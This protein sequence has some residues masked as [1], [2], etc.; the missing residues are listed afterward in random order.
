VHEVASEWFDL[1][2]QSLLS[3]PG[4]VRELRRVV[5]SQAGKRFY[6]DYVARLA[7]RVPK[8]RKHLSHFE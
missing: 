5:L 4:C 6:R 7:R 8:Y 3:T 2:F 1:M